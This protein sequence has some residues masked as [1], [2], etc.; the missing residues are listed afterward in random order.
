MPSVNRMSMKPGTW[1]EHE[2]IPAYWFGPNS[3][4]DPKALW[5]CNKCG[6]QSQEPMKPPVDF[7]VYMRG[8]NGN[9]IPLDCDGRA[10]FIVQEG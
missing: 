8:S 10:A 3:G 4:M 1:S 9:S 6:F 7:L 2:W 5:C